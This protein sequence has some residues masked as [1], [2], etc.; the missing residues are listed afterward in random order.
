[1][2]NSRKVVVTGRKDQQLVYRK[3]TMFP[4]GLKEKKF[5]DV[6]A[7]KPDEVRT[8]HMCAQSLYYS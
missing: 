7:D 4:G 1:V 6:K 2:T 3:H 8:A 5:K